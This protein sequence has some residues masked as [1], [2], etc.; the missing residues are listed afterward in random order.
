M[1]HLLQTLQ[2]IN[3]D[4]SD[5]N[6]V[7]Y[8]LDIN[9]IPWYP[10]TFV[11]PIPKFLIALLTKVGDTVLDPFGGKGTTAVESAKQARIPIY[12][13]LNPFAADITTALFQAIALTI[14]SPDILSD[15]VKRI[16]NYIVTAEETRNF[17]A[18]YGIN[19]DV[20][21]WYDQNSLAE[22]FSIINL[23]HHEFPRGIKLF[24]VRKLIL[25]AIFKQA[26]SQPG[27]FTYITDNCKPKT[28]VYKEAKKLYIDKICQLRLSCLDLVKQFEFAYPIEK[29]QNAILS[30][31]IKTGDARCLDWISDSTIN[32]VI[33][34]PPYLCAQDYIKTMRL[35]NLFFPNPIGFTESPQHEIGPR[36]KRRSKS[37]TVVADFY[38]DLNQVF[39]EIERVLVPN[40]YFCLIIGQGKSKI[41]SSY[42]TIS[43]LRQA[44]KTNYHFTEIYH[45]S[46]KISNR[47]IQVGGVDKEVIFIFQKS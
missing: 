9:S 15:E 33:T 28:L 36:N 35:T 37:G 46:R 4:F 24:N 7:K 31:I 26:S 10:A 29:L 42:D 8:P 22:L 34:S 25:T 44:I 47:V 38:A 13:D 27:H 6:S 12:N 19:V 32:L 11:S 30:A 14:E 45:V 43:D 20:F 2:N 18:R 21:S 40:G 3:W 17:A 39:S 1:D 5:Y 41:T 16:E 23:M